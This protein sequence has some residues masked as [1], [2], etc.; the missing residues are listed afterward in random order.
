MTDFLPI[1]AEEV[2]TILREKRMTSDVKIEPD[3]SL[4]EDLGLDSLAF[5]DLTLR[6]EARLQIPEL[7]LQDWIDA[8]GMRNGPKFTLSSLSEYAKRIIS[9]LA[10]G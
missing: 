7:P 8:E 9:G 5:T 1:I 10:D 6:L 2:L 4:V 3:T